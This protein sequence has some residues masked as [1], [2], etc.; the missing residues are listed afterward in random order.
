MLLSLRNELPI[1]NRLLKFLLIAVAAIVGIGLVAAIAFMM[2]FDPND[3]RDDISGQVSKATG[4]EFVIEGDLSVS[5][6][7]WLA[8]EV[9][10]SELGNAEG[11]G[12]LPFATFDQARLSVRLLPLLIRQEVAVGTATLDA[13]KLNL[14]VAANGA[15]NWE[16][17]ATA[18]EEVPDATTMPED[19]SAAPAA[20]DI[21]NVRITNANISYRDAQAGSA[22]TISALTLETDRI[23]MGEPFGLDAGF[24]FTAE[25]GE[26]GGRLEID[27]TVTLGEAFA[28]LMLDNLTVAGEV[29]G[30]AAE[31][32]D[33][34]LGA[35]SIAVDTDAETVSMGEIDLDALGLSVTALVEPFSYAGDLAVEANIRVLPFSL[36]D[37]M[38]TLGSESPVTADPAALTRVAFAANAA[39]SE[40]AARL[41]N[42]SLDLDDT[43]L[44]G[45]LSVPLT[46]DGRLEFTLAADSIDLDRYMAPA[47]E[48]PAADSGSTDDDIEIPVDLIRA[49]KA[50]GTVTL[51]R[52]TLAGMLFED[53]EVGLDSAEGRLRMHPISAKLF[54]GTYS[55]D[56]RIDATTATPSI[57]VNEKI[58]DVSLTPL[59]QAMFEQE[60]ISGTISG[61]FALS[62]RGQ[63]LAQ[64]RSDLDG[65]MAFALED[66]AWEGTDVWYQLRSAR[67]LFKQESPPERSNPPRTEFTSVVATG[68]VTDGVFRNDDLLAELPFLQLT[69]NGTVDLVK[70][71]VDYGMQARVL[72][73]PE[74]ATGATDSELADFTEAVIPLR[75]SG[76]LASPSI[77]PDIDGMLRAEVKKVVDEKRD[78]LQD[79]L[80]ERLLGGDKAPA[81]A[82]DAA[83]ASETG[84]PGDDPAEE[85][86]DVEDK[87]KDSLRRLFDQ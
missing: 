18:G 47:G 49:V 81:D 38:Q 23:A 69:G 72:E 64:I 62:G 40:T 84:K 55:G 9:G 28:S 42:L 53:L 29:R 37:L 15:N 39:I 66:G 57:S 70:A 20:L 14:Q 61:A 87:L 4:R 48:V 85:E 43:T 45:Q 33:L 60:N 3:F 24:D 21:A 78:E 73:R 50:R 44:T 83:E 56:V 82:A 80:L 17:L 8:V 11:F 67:A 76:P 71:E 10:R 25:P 36:K 27:G 59:A 79:K 86:K 6:F 7:P 13:L 2:F 5:L 1:M 77:R 46:E 41:T 19:D 26:L 31:P 16:D 52:A 58:A 12:E 51:E 30:L 22:Y 34:R 68:T 65:T 54:E 32:T 75:I 63:N 35:R 74:F